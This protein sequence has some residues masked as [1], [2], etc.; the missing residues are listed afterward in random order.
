MDDSIVC[1][2]PS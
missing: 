1:G 2:R